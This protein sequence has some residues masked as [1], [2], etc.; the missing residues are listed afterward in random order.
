[1]IIDGLSM[2]QL[3]HHE[4]SH[5]NKQGRINGF[6]QPWAHGVVLLLEWFE[7]GLPAGAGHEDAST[8]ADA[9]PKT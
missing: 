6:E 9:R 3:A 1:M 2:N 5:N 7:T 4:Q 8:P